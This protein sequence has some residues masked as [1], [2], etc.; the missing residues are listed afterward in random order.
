MPKLVPITPKKL[1]KILRKLGFEQRDGEG[2]H[3]FF[4]H[5]DGRT[6]VVSIHTRE[7]GRGLLRKILSDIQITVE[8]YDRLR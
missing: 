5:E 6:T 2:S 1:V 3:L 7:M 4:R 8:E